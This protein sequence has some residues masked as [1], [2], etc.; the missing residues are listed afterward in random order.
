MR[1]GKGIF[2][3]RSTYQRGLDLLLNT[4]NHLDPTLL[5][6]RECNDR[7]QGWIR[8]HDRYAA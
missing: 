4:Y 6:R 7:T 2:H 8:H 3:T 1:E 5:G